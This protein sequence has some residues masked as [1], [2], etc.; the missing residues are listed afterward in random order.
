[1]G[2]SSSTRGRNAMPRRF[3]FLAVSFWACL[4]C[5]SH[6]A[7]VSHATAADSILALEQIR[8]KALLS[9]DTLTLSRLVANEFIEISRLGEVRTKYDNLHDLSTGT[10]KISSVKYDS[11][12]VRVYGNMAVLF[13]IADNK[14]TFRGFPW[15]G[16]VRYLRVFIRRDGRWQAVASQQTALP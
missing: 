13:G 7:S 9:A 16:K 1:M 6:A 15:G 3:V 14:G 5:Y 12:N 11:L 2:V 8:G 4:A 10:L